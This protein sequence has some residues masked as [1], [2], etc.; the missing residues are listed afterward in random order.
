MGAH[1]RG[2]RDLCPGCA[3]GLFIALGERGFF[4]TSGDYALSDGDVETKPLRPADPTGLTGIGRRLHDVA[5][6]DGQEEVANVLIYVFGNATCPDC[7][8][9]F[10]VAAQISAGQPAPLG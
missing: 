1:E 5:L 3:A 8:T 9:D 6:A 4:S 7:E 10:S 2:V